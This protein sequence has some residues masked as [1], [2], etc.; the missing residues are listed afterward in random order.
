MENWF[1]GEKL[2]ARGKFAEGKMPNIGVTFLEKKK[3]RVNM[4][5]VR[6]PEF[7]RLP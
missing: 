1:F 5:L 4:A 3:K 6:S 2:I 7:F